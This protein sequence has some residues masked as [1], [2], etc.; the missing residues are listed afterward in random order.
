M[1]NIIKSIAL[2]AVASFALVS[3]NKE[4]PSKAEVE[5]GFDPITKSLPTVTIGNEVTCDA[6]N[7]VANVNI[8]LS[9]LDTSLDSLEVGVLS[10][11]TED[12]LVNKFAKVA[13]PAD[14]TLSVPAIVTA[15]KTYYLKAVVSSTI[16]AVYSEAITVDVPD[17]P[18]WAKLAG[19]WACTISSEAYGDEYENV[20]TLINNPENPEN[21]V[22]VLHLEPYYYSKYGDSEYGYPDY[23]WCVATIDNEKNCFSIPVGASY[24]YGGRMI[25]GLDSDSMKTATAYAPVVFSIVDDD[26]LLQENAFQTVKS[27]GSAEDSYVGKVTYKRQ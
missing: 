7:G 18:F 11:T 24:N 4:A 22:F 27:D 9:G 10:S 15:N 16:G 25:A 21:E 12:F 20:V 13:N 5:K 17:I 14:G 23:F 26:T 6:V 2:V 8:T 3:C 19:N 1:R